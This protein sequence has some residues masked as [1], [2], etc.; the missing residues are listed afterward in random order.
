MQHNRTSRKAH[1]SNSFNEPR[2]GKID[3][4]LPVQATCAGACSISPVQGCCCFVRT[5]CEAL[6]K[7]VARLVN[8]AACCACLDLGLLSLHAF[9]ALYKLAFDECS[10]ASLTKWQAKLSLSGVASL[11]FSLQ[12]H[13]AARQAHSTKQHPA[14]ERLP[15]HPGA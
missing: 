11:T 15:D 13:F 2:R 10:W 7:L 1:K 9:L 8:H 6:F 3:E 12:Q 5:D 14:S 4:K